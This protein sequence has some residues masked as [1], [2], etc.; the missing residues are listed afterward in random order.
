MLRYIVTSS[1]VLL[2]TSC[3][4]TPSDAG[5]SSRESTSGQASTS[6][7]QLDSVTQSLLGY[8][9][10]DFGAH[11]PVVAQVRNVR[12][13]HVLTARGE[14]QYLLCGEFVPAHS[15]RKGEWTTFATIKTDPYEQWL[16]GQAE[17]WCK[18]AKVKWKENG[19][20]LSSALRTRLDALK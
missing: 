16:G 12:V 9:A 14:K 6:G 13:G 18:N 11:S 17:S 3:S 19:R 2:L 1:V 8:A 7:E 5:T 15:E 20:D 10:S 4:T